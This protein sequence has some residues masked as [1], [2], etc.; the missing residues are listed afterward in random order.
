MDWEERGVGAATTKQST[1]PLTLTLTGEGRVTLYA[2][3][4]SD[5]RT[6]YI[7]WYVYTAITNTAA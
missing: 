6:K 2:G 1:K 3:E 7:G 4:W 5:Y